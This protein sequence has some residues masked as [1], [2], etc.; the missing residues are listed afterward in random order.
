M[1]IEYMNNAWKLK[2]EPSVKFIFITLAD[3]CDHQG[4]CFPSIRFISQRTGFSEST[5]HR[6]I[7]DLEEMG[8][9]KRE[10]QVRKNGSDSTNKYTIINA[11]PPPTVTPTPPT[12]TP[13]GSHH[14]T[15]Y[16]HHLDPSSIK[17]KKTKTKKEKID[18]AIAPCE[19]ENDVLFEKLYEDYPKEGRKSHT[20]AKAVFSKV[21]LSKDTPDKISSS[22]EAQKREK[23]LHAQYGLFRPRFKDIASWIRKKRWL[24]PVL[25]EQEI[26]KL[27]QD[28]ARMSG[29]INNDAQD[30]YQRPSRMGMSENAR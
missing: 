21:D 10:K 7:S 16:N 4:Q 25:T 3:C 6:A 19:S 30:L 18:V 15:P 22:L 1:S 13:P 20:E 14:D 8:F 26:R 9:L 28:Q 27:A 17:N 23:E 5:V 24:D 12:V 2:L 29:K 11:C